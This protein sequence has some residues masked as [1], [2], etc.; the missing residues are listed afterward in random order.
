M[1][2]GPWTS[3]AR[4]KQSQWLP[5]WASLCSRFWAGAKWVQLQHSGLQPGS[6]KG[7]RCL[8]QLGSLV[9]SHTAPGVSTSFFTETKTAWF[10]CTL[11]QTPTGLFALNSTCSWGGEK[12][13]AWG[14]TT[15]S[16]HSFFPLSS[17]NWK[18]L[19]PP[20]L[21]LNKPNFLEAVQRF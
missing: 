6:V 20:C 13:D 5:G 3:S 12:P 9:K 15:F 18:Y 17:R 2:E 16:G 7:F 1:A 14:L 21:S 8:K 4:L 19:L 11:L 10:E